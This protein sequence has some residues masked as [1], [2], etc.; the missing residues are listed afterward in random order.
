M[1]QTVEQ[2][3]DYELDY[4]RG[5]L[6]ARSRLYRDQIRVAKENRRRLKDD[7]QSVIAGLARIKA[8]QQKR[9]KSV[10]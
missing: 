6:L 9:R 10:Q 3:L 2:M 7:H 1:I 5:A 8:E 4:W